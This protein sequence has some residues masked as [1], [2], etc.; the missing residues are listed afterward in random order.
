MLKYSDLPEL[1]KRWV[2]IRRGDTEYFGQII[3]RSEAIVATS[4][5]TV[6]RPWVLRTK[7]G[8]I[9]FVPEDRWDIELVK[10]NAV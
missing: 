10:D 5:E 9:D 6:V 1:L 2:R 8:D 4:V 3:G 7:D